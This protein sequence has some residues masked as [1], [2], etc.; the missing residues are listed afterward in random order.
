[1]ESIWLHAPLSELAQNKVRVTER[2]FHCFEELNPGE[3]VF[4]RRHEARKQERFPVVR[5][6]TIPE[7]ER[8]RGGYWRPERLQLP[9][10]P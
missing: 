1:M 10:L 3:Q 4:C 2:S 7:E 8:R 9:R 5:V 6:V